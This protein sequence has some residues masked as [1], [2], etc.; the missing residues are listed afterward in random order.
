VELVVKVIVQFASSAC[1]EFLHR[2]HRRG[3][4]RV[5]RC[6]SSYCG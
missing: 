3:G 2:L 1:E 4:R 5:A 6:R